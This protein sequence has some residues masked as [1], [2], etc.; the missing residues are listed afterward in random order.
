[1]YWFS[2]LQLWWTRFLVMTGMGIFHWFKQSMKG[3]LHL[4]SCH[5]QAERVLLLPPQFGWHL[6]NLARASNKM[7]NQ[8]SKNGYPCLAHDFTGRVFSLSLLWCSSWV[9]HKQP[10]S[11]G[12]NS[13]LFLVCYMVLWW[14]GVGFFQMLFTLL[15][16]WACVFPPSF[17]YYA[18]LH[19]FISVFE[20]TLHFS[21]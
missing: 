18:A 8:S 6:F 10:L 17:Y 4:I 13:L 3:F 1:M 14:K 11:D 2:I 20:S 21:G 16:R 9:F 12:V 5:G 7:M 19:W 15:L